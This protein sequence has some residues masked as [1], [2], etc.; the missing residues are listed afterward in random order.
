MF[1]DRALTCVHRLLEVNVGTTCACLPHLKPLLSRYLPKILGE[2]GKST[3][4]PPRNQ[5]GV[6]AHSPLETLDYIGASKA[7]GVERGQIQLPRSLTSRCDD[8]ELGEENGHGST[9]NLCSIFPCLGL[10]EM[11]TRS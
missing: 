8:L 4:Y 3:S 6:R 10:I 1:Y 7:E 11:T 5:M 2:T 9:F